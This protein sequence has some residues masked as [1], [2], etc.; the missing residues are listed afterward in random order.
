FLM[1]RT[2]SPNATKRG[3][4]MIALFKKQ[5]YH[6]VMIISPRHI[7][8]IFRIFAVRFTNHKKNGMSVCG[9][10]SNKINWKEY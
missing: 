9:A 4:F 8:L 7:S 5:N 6:Y 1:W 2:L 3:S 10:T